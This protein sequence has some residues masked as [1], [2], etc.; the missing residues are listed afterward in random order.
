MHV[1]EPGERCSLALLLLQL[2]WLR[3][4]VVVVV[5][6][7]K[8]QT[9][10][11][12]FSGSRR[13]SLRSLRRL[14]IDS[15]FDSTWSNKNEREREIGREQIVFR[16]IQS[17]KSTFDSWRQPYCK[18]I[19]SLVD[20]I[21]RPPN[22]IVGQIENVPRWTNRIDEQ[23]DFFRRFSKIVS[24]FCDDFIEC[25]A[26][27]S[28]WSALDQS[29]I[30]FEERRREKKIHLIIVNV[31]KQHDVVEFAHLCSDHHA[32]YGRAHGTDLS[33]AKSLS[34]YSGSSLG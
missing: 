14:S 24:S 20:F 12:R 18:W 7:S 29:A 22:F 30:G 13:H 26:V 33:R 4:V 21:H 3:L 9:I 17:S 32:E 6:S 23:K 19:S 15:S 16:R 2:D 8:A 5:H 1:E 28:N 11:S 31:K 10:R 34:G 25:S 27:H